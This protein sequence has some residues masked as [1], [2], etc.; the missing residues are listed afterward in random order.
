MITRPVDGAGLVVALGLG[1]GATWWASRGRTVDDTNPAAGGEGRLPARRR[2]LAWEIAV[3]VLAMLP[4]VVIQ[5]GFDEGITGRWLTLPWA[6]LAARNDPYDTVSVAPLP[7]GVPHEPRSVVPRVRAFSDAVSKPAYEAKIA[8][9]SLGRLRERALLPT[10]RNGL[11]D[12]L[13]LVLLP[14]SMLGLWRRGRW[15]LVAVLPLFLVVYSRY[16][17]VVAHYVTSVTPALIVMVL[18]GWDAVAALWGRTGATV[19]R[20]AGGAMLATLAL[21]ALPQVWRE[22]PADEWDIAPVLRLVDERIGETVRPPAVVLF[23]AEPGAVSFHIE[24]TYNTDVA[25]P[26]DAAIVRAH[27]LGPERNRRLFAYYAARARQRG[28][29][30]RAVYLY[31]LS[32]ATLNQPP[33]YLGTAGELAAGK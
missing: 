29:T 10:L 14:V 27:D 16:T 22:A 26:D 18:V 32:P 30:D 31:D 4:F 23:R 25:W 7:P 1:M 28:M 17:Y 19:V 3:P 5:L 21:A 2:R 20:I 13:L 8:L 6:Y 11:P 9:S 24:P 15:V 33:K 12:P